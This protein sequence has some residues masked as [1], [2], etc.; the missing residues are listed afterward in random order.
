MTPKQVIAFALTATSP[1]PTSNWGAQ[2]QAGLDIT[3]P[4]RPIEQRHIGR[5][6][7]HSKSSQ[8]ELLQQSSAARGT[9][10]PAFSGTTT[11]VAL[12]AR[13]NVPQNDRVECMSGRFDLRDGR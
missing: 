10:V 3:I 8:K 11:L 5:C 13:G 2:H 9:T 6:N 12:S 4:G 7:P 1:A